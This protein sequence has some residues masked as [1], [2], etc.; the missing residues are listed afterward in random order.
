M[1]PNSQDAL[2][3]PRRPD[4]ERYKKLAGDLVQACKSPDAGCRSKMG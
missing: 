4:L 2:P 1:F 3:L